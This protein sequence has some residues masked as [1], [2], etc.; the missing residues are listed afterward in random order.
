[1]FS[2]ITVESHKARI[3]EKLNIFHRRDLVQYAQNHNICLKN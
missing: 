1:M 3:K 2:L